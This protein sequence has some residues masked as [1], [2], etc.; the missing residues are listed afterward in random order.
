MAQSAPAAEELAYA[1]ITPYSLHK[2]RTGGIIARL[3]WAN[4]KLVAARM[5]APRPD[6]SFI[7]EYCDALY[8]PDE[9]HIPLRYQKMLI[10][11][12]VRNFGKPN[13]RGISNR[14]FVLVFRGQNAV[15][16][17]VEA[18]GHISQHVQGDNVRGTFGDFIG[19]D[20]RLVEG[21]PG[22]RSRVR[23]FERYAR[24]REVEVDRMQNDLFEPAVLTGI[25]PGMTEAHLE[26]PA[27][28][29]LQRRR[30]RAGRAGRAGPG[31]D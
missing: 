19:E 3:L 11:Y 16:E 26:D 12:I 28:V 1:L 8:D 17:V 23:R 15:H 22:Y 30:P 6:G 27:Q 20:S 24:L 13:V 9:R 14:M 25:S 5:Y 2:S 7:D 31:P 10:G 21:D 18:V 29:C 4:V